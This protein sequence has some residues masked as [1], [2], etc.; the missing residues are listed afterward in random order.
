MTRPGLTA[1]RG[2]F[3]WLVRLLQRCLGPRLV[4]GQTRPDAAKRKSTGSFRDL[5]DRIADLARTGDK[6]IYFAGEDRQRNAIR[7]G[8]AACPGLKMLADS[9]ATPGL[10]GRDR[11]PYPGLSFIHVR[12]LPGRL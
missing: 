7:K 8:D 3:D 4:A 9:T 5:E 1:T 6:M 11:T 2:R 12:P 10:I